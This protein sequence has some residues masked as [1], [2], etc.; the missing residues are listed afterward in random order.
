VRNNFEGFD[1]ARPLPERYV[2]KFK[3]AGGFYEA[4]EAVQ[5]CRDKKRPGI[6]PGSLI[7]RHTIHSISAILPTSPISANY[8]K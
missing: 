7:I 6:G 4:A 1:E 8:G 5:V 2:V 3:P